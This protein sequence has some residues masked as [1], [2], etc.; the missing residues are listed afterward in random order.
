MFILVLRKEMAQQLRAVATSSKDPGLISSTHG[1]AH[2][3]LQFQFQRIWCPLLASMGTRHAQ[4]TQIH[5]QARYSYIWNWHFKKKSLRTF[6]PASICSEMANSSLNMVVCGP[7]S[8]TAEDS[9]ITQSPSHIPYLLCMCSS[10]HTRHSSLPPSLSPLFLSLPISTESLPFHCWLL[11][12]V[13]SY[14]KTP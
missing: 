4:G 9:P 14:T 1:M 12:K 3:H 8:P 10:L 11:R 5:I 13:D 6:L 2:N 7:A